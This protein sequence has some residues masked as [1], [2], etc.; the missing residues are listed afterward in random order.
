[1]IGSTVNNP[2]KRGRWR[3]LASG[4]SLLFVALLI[5]GFI[6]P[7]FSHDADPLRIVLPTAGS[8]FKPGEQLK[9]QWKY[10]AVPEPFP[11]LVYLVRA[12]SGATER[13]ALGWNIQPDPAAATTFDWFIP[14]S[15]PAGQYVVTIANFN[16]SVQQSS[17]A[18]TIGAL[19]QVA[20]IEAHLG[21]IAR[22]SGNLV[23][24]R[25][26]FERSESAA[27]DLGDKRLLAE[28]LRNLASLEL[29][30]SEV[31]KA[32][33]LAQQSL[34]LAAAAGIKVDVGRALI[35]LGECEAQTLFH[36]QGD[37]MTSAEE[38]FQQ[39]VDLFRGIGNEAELG[40]ALERLGSFRIERGELE[41]GK[42]IVGEAQDIFG[43]LGMKKFG[44]L[45]DRLMTELE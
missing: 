29:A 18:F 15:I 26:R 12:D 16:A 13:F 38:Y 9:I 27:R 43:R 45:A 31:D 7:S 34:D 40:V 17:G 20:I 28:A 8:I 11:A 4:V 6:K 21:E 36:D 41:I 44:A 5:S 30:N 14:N 32:R 10:Q 24:A 42:V 35:V 22:E 19:P 33:E 23:E 3:N 37:G 25:R 1:M 2:F 39:A